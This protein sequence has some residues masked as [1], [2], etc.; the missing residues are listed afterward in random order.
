MF[1]ILVK[2]VFFLVAGGGAEVQLD[3]QAVRVLEENL[4]KA[5][6]VEDVEAQIDTE[7]LQVFQ[8]R[9]EIRCIERD[10]I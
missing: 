8:C 4:S 6:L 7:I 3:R 5:D 10:V 2:G 1:L 9:I